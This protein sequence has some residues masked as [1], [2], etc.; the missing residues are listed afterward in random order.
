[1]EQPAENAQAPA[2]NRVYD[3]IEDYLSAVTERLEFR[4]VLFRSIDCGNGATGV[5]AEALFKA[6]GCE[7]VML[8]DEVDGDFPNHHPDPADPDNLQDLIDAVQTHDC[9]LG[10]AFDGDGDRLGV[11]TPAGEIIW[12]DRQLILFARDILARH[13]GSTI[14]YDVKC[15][16]H[17][18]LAIKAEIGVPLKIGRASV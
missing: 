16:R 12:P 9:A 10:L 3:P 4:R 5:V 13:P 18:G 7:I 11:V 1:M 2:I 6:L 14:I 15:S 17:V 8:Y